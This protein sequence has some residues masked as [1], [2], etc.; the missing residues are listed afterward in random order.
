MVIILKRTPLIRFDLFCYTSTAELG[1]SHPTSVWV[2]Q[3]IYEG[4]FTIAALSHDQ[5]S[6]LRFRP[7]NVSFANGRSHQLYD[8]SWPA[9]IALPTKQAEF[10]LKALL[11]FVPPFLSHEAHTLGLQK[12]CSIQHEK[13]T[14]KMTSEAS[15]KGCLKSL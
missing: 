10:V 5:S 3:R 11:C 9:R 7:S 4:A 6:S 8:N 14:I 12:I 2:T 15:M 13:G 1:L